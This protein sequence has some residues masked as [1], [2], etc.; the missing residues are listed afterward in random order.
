VQPV[1]PVQPVQPI[2]PVIPIQ[3]IQPIEPI[4]LP[5]PVAG[6]GGP[7]GGPAESEASGQGTQAQTAG[8]LSAEDVAALEKLVVE[9]DADLDL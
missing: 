4:V 9:E 7:G 5:P 1:V 6:P 3:P 8:R 2:Q